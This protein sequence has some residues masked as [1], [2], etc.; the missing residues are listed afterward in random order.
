MKTH[1]LI[2]HFTYFSPLR[3]V[4]GVRLIKE[5]GVIQLSISQRTL[6]AFGQT[7]ESEQDTWKV[8]FYQFAA[9]DHGPVND[10]DYFTISY[11][12]RSINLDDLVLP[13]GKLVTGVRFHNLNGHLV[14]QIRATDFDYFTGRLENI[15][16]NPWAMN[17]GGGQTELE[18]P[19]KSN[20]LETIV[21]DLYI[22]ENTPNAYVRFG[23]SDVEF[24][25][26]QSTVPFID[27]LPLES[28][29]PVALGGI[30]LTFKKNKESGGFI[31]VKTITY[32]FAIADV[33]ID[34]E[35]D[36]ID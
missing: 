6:M 8:S 23:P 28:R 22:P 1:E 3:V 34:E 17:E 36:Y 16:H 4:T 31:A 30:G 2:I 10:V 15:T 19:K 9:T 35:Y 7:D 33:T 12:N 32:D 29:N 11:E 14:L 21:S 13:Q 5:N 24:D 25:V 26:G 18:I 27:T 20:P